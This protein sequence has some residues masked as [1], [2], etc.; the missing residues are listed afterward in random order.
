MTSNVCFL[1]SNNGRGL[2]AFGGK[3]ILVIKNVSSLNDIDTFINER[4]NK[5]IFLCLSYD[6][7]N[8]IES[9]NS[10]NNDSTCFPDLVFW[11]PDCVF[12]I[13]NESLKP[14]Q[15]TSTKEQYKF[16]KDFISKSKSQNHKEV[17]V[18]FEA[19]ISRDTYL[20]KVNAIKKHIQRGDIYEVNFCQEY[21]AKN[22]EKERVKEF[23]TNLNGITKAP[24]S[25]YFKFSDFEVFCGSPERF[26]QKQGDILTT[27]PIK[28]TAKRGI[29]KSEDLQLANDLKNDPKER[30]E[31]IMIVDL[32]RNDLS[33]IARKGTVN[34]DELCEVYTYKTVHQMVSKVSCQLR[35]NQSFTDIIKA[36]F[37]MG[38]MTGAPKIRAMELIEEYENFKRGLYSGSIGYI[39]PNGDFDLNVV[40]RTIIYNSKLKSLSCGVGSAITIKSDAEKEYE[41]CGIKVQKILDG[42][43]G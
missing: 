3:D 17:K 11:S 26:I 4:P 33:K 7:K 24:F 10:S 32:M 36:T 43:S 37:P 18:Q 42:I 6:L 29:N 14:L 30:A 16:A 22:I 15:G 1:N 9:L 12:D 39:S 25:S 21:V 38:S 31:N 8:G 41:E 40:I 23:Y 13:K 34:V 2:L 28:G 35:E 20:N 19:Q 27:Q 5:Y